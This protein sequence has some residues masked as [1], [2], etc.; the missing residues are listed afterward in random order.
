[1]AHPN[2]S[3]G[4]Y[5]DFIA[6]GAGANNNMVLEADRRTNGIAIR[7]SWQI[8]INGKTLKADWVSVDYA[9]GNGT[10]IVT[11]GGN[12][13]SYNSFSWNAA[14]GDTLIINSYYKP[15]GSNNRNNTLNSGGTIITNNSIDT[16][17]KVM[18]YSVTGTTTVINNHWWGSNGSGSITVASG[19]RYAGDGSTNVAT[20]TIHG[21]VSP[22][23]GGN[24]DSGISTL[25]FGT[26]T[27][28]NGTYAMDISGV[29]CDKI[30]AQ[31]LNLGAASK[32]MVSGTATENSYVI[33]TYTGLTGTFDLGASSLP[34]N[35][36][37]DYHF[38]GLNQIALVKQ[39]TTVEAPTFSPVAGTY[40]TAQSVT[41]STTTS[42]ASIRY[43]TDG[44]TP[45]ETVGTE[46]F[47]PVNI[48]VNSTLKAIA[49]KGGTS[50][51]VSS[52]AYIITDTIVAAPTFDPPAGTYA[53]AQAVT[54]SSATSGATIRYTTNGTTPSESIGT[55]YTEPVSIGLAA[56]LKAIAYKTGM[57][58]SAVSTG[59]YTITTGNPGF[60]WTGG[61]NG[62]WTTLSN[63]L[64]DG[65][66]ASRYPGNGND[67]DVVFFGIRNPGANDPTSNQSRDDRV[68]SLT[69]QDAWNLN[70]GGR[71]LRMDGVSVNIPGGDGTAS[72]FGANGMQSYNSLNFSATAG[73][74]L[75]LACIFKPVG[76]G[77]ARTHGFT[78]GGTVAANGGFD[79]D[80]KTINY[81]VQG[82]TT[83]LNNF[84]MNS[85]GGDTGSLVVDA[86]SVVGGDGNF[87]V[88]N[89]TVNGTISPSGGGNANTGVSTLTFSGALNLN[90]TF[91]ADI[92]DTTC[93][94]I[95][96]AGALTLGD[97]SKLVVTG[98]PTA[99]AYIVAT[100]TSLSGTFDATTS[101]LPSGYALNYA[102]QGNQIALVNTNP[103]LIA[104][105]T[106]VASSQNPSSAGEWV[107]FTATVAPATGAIVPTG[108]VRFKIDGVALGAPVTV[109]AGTDSNGT[110][111]I[112]T[113]SITAAGSPHAVTAEFNAI[114]EF[115]N[116]TGTLTPG[117]TVITTTATTTTLASSINP[118]TV[119]QSVTFTATII[120]A[121]GAVVPT[122]TAQFWLDGVELGSPVAVTQGTGT[123]GTA[124]IA[125]DSI[126]I[127]GS[128]HDVTVDYVPT[129]TFLASSGSLS[130][131]QTVTLLTPFQSWAIAKGLTSGNN[132][133]G[134]D[135]DGDG[136]TNQQE[137]AFGLDPM[138][139]SSCNPITMPLDKATGKFRYTRNAS[140][141]LTY[142]VL[143]SSDL[144]TWAPEAPV[145]EAFISTADGVDTMEVTVAA[146][147]VNGRLFVKVAAE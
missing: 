101:I 135:P 142:G 50:S 96:C 75:V 124:S 73:D 67:G 31:T 119:G 55:E 82:G 141:G 134:D 146:P 87:Q 64:Y 102:F 27:N 129:G 143:T 86:T 5:L 105:T 83:L 138:N 29:A 56:N 114:G 131:G 48:A 115:I 98:T 63:W 7:D 90:G 118:S 116:S 84:Y 94:K 35:Y 21:T 17:G 130:G 45:T 38:D 77:S 15:V 74:T 99:Y 69:F 80:T 62:N 79:N 140:S 4:D 49:Y 8:N 93:D 3:S 107:T 28:L 23:D 40:A 36:A 12:L 117:Q 46:Y 20:T 100:Y 65:L 54:I 10:G 26:T 97:T 120:P 41:I 71:W 44:S 33:A 66:A 39:A 59:S 147:P 70:L 18:D 110:A 51:P 88:L 85:T 128:P 104:T 6:K 30:A 16:D 76:S 43:T 32:L 13:Q 139:G 42:G 91:A 37:L 137:F 92:V 106:T 109:T 58:T 52:G 122:G 61:T 145:N 113:N 127:A 125:T 95:A 11:G 123:N 34:A 19:A 2:D 108:T 14:P 78:G 132:Q 68:A 47:T 22:S 136:Q 57:T 144:Q 89:S 112:S 24:A 53:A 72:I 133:P 9:V 126:T 81:T 25:S 60:T 1:V 111:E 103:G 121:T